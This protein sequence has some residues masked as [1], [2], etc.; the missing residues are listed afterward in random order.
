MLAA[1]AVVAAINSDLI[2]NDVPPGILLVA[3]CAVIGA[4]A[5]TRQPR[6]LVGWLFLAV[7]VVS[8]LQDVCIEL[9]ILL[10]RHG[11]PRPVFQWLAWLSDRQWILIIGPLFVL[12]PLLFPDG[13]PPSRRWRGVGWLAVSLIF[14]QAVALAIS[15]TTAQ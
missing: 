6:N 10:Y 2:V 8:V 13:R 9:A 15:S 12:L 11:G 7:A 3:T 14:L 5:I 1:A 4:L